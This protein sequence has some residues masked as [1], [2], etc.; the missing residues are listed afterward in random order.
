MEKFKLHSEISSYQYKRKLLF[1]SWMKKLDQNIIKLSLLNNIIQRN[2]S[3]VYSLVTSHCNWHCI[4]V[5]FCYPNFWPFLIFNYRILI[6]LVFTF[7]IMI[8]NQT[9][10]FGEI[11]RNFR[12]KHNV[13]KL[14][15]WKNFGLHWVKWPIYASYN[16][17]MLDCDFNKVRQKVNTTAFLT[18]ARDLRCT[19]SIRI[20]VCLAHYPPSPS[21][22]FC[23]SRTVIWQLMRWHVHICIFYSNDCGFI[24]IY[25]YH[26][27]KWHSI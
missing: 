7:R 15:N 1:W 20:Y 8:W 5:I 10:K 19:L 22:H 27:S 21:P 14:E 17:S 12:T 24:R 4:I 6:F 9:D 26:I 18:D 16:I 11:R 23:H 13:Q 3:Q 25:T 2:P